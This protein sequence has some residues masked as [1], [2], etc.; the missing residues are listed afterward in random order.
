MLLHVFYYFVIFCKLVFFILFLMQSF[1]FLLFHN[2]FLFLQ[3]MITRSFFTLIFKFAHVHNVM[4][5]DFLIFSILNRSVIRYTSVGC[6]SLFLRFIIFTIFVRFCIISLNH[7]SS[8]YMRTSISDIFSYWEFLQTHQLS[9]FGWFALVCF[10]QLTQ[11]LHQKNIFC[12][13]LSIFS[14]LFPAVSHPF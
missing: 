14:H 12:P 10:F 11:K 6:L 9:Y 13:F 1:Y 5:S 4:L 7:F 8:L 2:C 3:L